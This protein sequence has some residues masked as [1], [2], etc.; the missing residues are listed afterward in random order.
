MIKSAKI[1]MRILW[2]AE[3][4]EYAPPVEQ[5]LIAAGHKVASLS[6]LEED[7]PTAVQRLQPDAL[8]L[9]TQGSGRELLRTLR[10]VYER[11]PLPIVVFTD[12]SEHDDIRFAI[13]AGVSAY[14]VDGL[15]ADRVAPVLDAAVARFL[16]FQALRSE[17]DDAIAKLNER[18]TIERAKGI[19]MRRRDLP[20]EAAY[21]VLRKMAMNRG[22]R[23]I[24]VADS[25][26]TA[27]Q[28]LTQNY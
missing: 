1:P 21:D 16:E 25:I 10:R 15:R 20:E 4:R 19:L 12:K 2:V 22:R 23:M 9:E 3:R 14:V 13:R 7:L 8:L 6:A 18:R 24:E 5:A 27:E 17:R 28:A 11:R 26:I